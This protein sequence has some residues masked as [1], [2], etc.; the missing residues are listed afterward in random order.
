MRCGP[1][2]GAAGRPSRAR[3]GS[4]ARP[5]GRGPRARRSR[6]TGAAR[7]AARSRAISASSPAAPSRRRHRPSSSSAAGLRSVEARSRRCCGDCAALNAL[8]I[9]R[10]SSGS[11]GAGKSIS[12]Q[13]LDLAVDGQH[14]RAR[15]R[16]AARRRR[17]EDDG[18]PGPPAAGTRITSPGRSCSSDARRLGALRWP[19]ARAP[20]PPRGPTARRRSAGVLPEVA[21]GGRSSPRGSPP[22]PPRCAAPA[23]PARRPPGRPGTA[24]TTTPAASRARS[25][26]TWP[27]RLTAM[28]Y[29]GRKLERSG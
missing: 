2:P 9:R 27:T 4:S 1:R 19:R 25:R 18:E 3:A 29:D 20:A 6:G 14:Q 13:L 22:A 24:R 17:V 28:L 8:G 16:R 23:G 15:V 5:S 21:R 7:S 12:G 11:T 10:G 26:P